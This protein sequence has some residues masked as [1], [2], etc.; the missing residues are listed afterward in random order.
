MAASEEEATA[1]TIT[2]EEEDSVYQIG[3]Y[4][5]EKGIVI[6]PEIFSYKEKEPESRKNIFMVRRFDNTKKYNS[7]IDFDMSQF[8]CSNDC[9]KC[10]DL[11]GKWEWK[12]IGMCGER[13]MYDVS[14]K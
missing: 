3:A 4:L 11:I 13:N 5:Q 7:S 8:E 1:I 6:N 9:Y 2:V 10:G 12:I 14:G